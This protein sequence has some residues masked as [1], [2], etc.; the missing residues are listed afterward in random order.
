ML[1]KISIKGM[2]DKNL[3]ERG[4]DPIMPSCNNFK[5]VALCKAHDSETTHITTCKGIT[6][7][8][9]RSK[10]ASSHPD[11]ATK[12]NIAMLSFK[13]VTEILNLKSR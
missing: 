13:G 2:K 12:E 11:R 9:K 8:F 10:G 5:G 1:R 7:G 6:W 3:H 4:T